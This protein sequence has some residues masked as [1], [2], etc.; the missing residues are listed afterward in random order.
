MKLISTSRRLCIPWYKP[1]K[2]VDA[3]KFDNDWGGV[4]KAEKCNHCG[5]I[6]QTC[7][8]PYNN[9]YYYVLG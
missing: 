4:V 9:K 3:P 7:H 6:R 8:K 2:W 1:H 5:L